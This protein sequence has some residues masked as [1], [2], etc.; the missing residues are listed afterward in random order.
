M[1]Y[2]APRAHPF[3]Y[4]RFAFGAVA[5]GDEKDGALAFGVRREKPGDVIIEKGEAG[6]AEP[7]GV[8]GKIKLA[9]E[10]AGFKL[11]DAIAAI[12]ETL[13]NGAQVGEEEDVHGGIGGQILS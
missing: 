4:L 3:P 8:R 12:A 5:E 6:G 10:D 2:R 11:H 13:Q 7:L 9:A 1:G